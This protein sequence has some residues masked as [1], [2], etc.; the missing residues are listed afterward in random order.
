MQ[1]NA[2]SLTLEAPPMIGECVLLVRMLIL[3]GVPCGVELTLLRPLPDKLA[4]VLN[5][6]AC[7]EVNSACFHSVSSKGT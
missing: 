7:R 1:D 5:C 3:M 6:R 2:L 4:G